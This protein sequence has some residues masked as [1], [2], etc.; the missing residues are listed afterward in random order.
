[1]TAAAIL[2]P[3]AWP[4]GLLALAACAAVMLAAAVGLALWEERWRR[5]QG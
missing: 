2:L 1:M 5:R 4:R 3:S